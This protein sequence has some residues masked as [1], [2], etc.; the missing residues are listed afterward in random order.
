MHET[1]LDLATRI[2]HPAYP[3]PWWIGVHGYHPGLGAVEG[4]VDH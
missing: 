3:N 1:S 2:S 4:H